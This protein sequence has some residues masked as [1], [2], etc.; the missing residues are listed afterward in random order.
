LYD[1]DEVLSVGVELCGPLYDGREVALGG[2]A[3]DRA[4]KTSVRQR[5]TGDGRSPPRLAAAMEA[6]LEQPQISKQL[7]DL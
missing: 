5:I 3:F 1:V 4:P 2:C 6:Q 7:R